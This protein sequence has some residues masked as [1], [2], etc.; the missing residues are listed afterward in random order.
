MVL[1]SADVASAV[2]RDVRGVAGTDYTC[3]IRPT[4]SGGWEAQAYER[5]TPPRP[6]EVR[7]WVA[8]APQPRPRPPSPLSSP[9][10]PSLP[11]SP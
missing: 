1:F 11:P 6:G 2:E 4:A 7:A 9:R 10:S 5:V 8:A 3:R